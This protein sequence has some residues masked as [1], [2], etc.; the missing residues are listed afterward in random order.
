L[1]RPFAFDATTKQA[2][3]RNASDRLQCIGDYIHNLCSGRAD[4]SPLKVLVLDDFFCSPLNGWLCGGRSIRSAG[5]V[6]RYLRDCAPGQAVELTVKFVHTYDEWRTQ[7]GL[8]VQVGS[9]LTQASYHEACEF[10]A[11]IEATSTDAGHSSP[12]LSDVGSSDCQ[13]WE[14]LDSL[15]DE[16]ENGAQSVMLVAKEQWANV[17]H[18][19]R[20]RVAQ[21]AAD[22]W[23]WISVSLPC[24]RP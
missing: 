7:S 4:C 11:C 8:R 13:S 24:L 9:G 19:V 21:I 12:A 6:E 18:G 22:G 20:R 14:D 5:A 3:E 10:L 17:Q 15:W 16:G 2:N 23:S 1:G